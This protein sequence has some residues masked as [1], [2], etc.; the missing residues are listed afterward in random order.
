MATAG[1]MSSGRGWGMCD[2]A[3][4]SEPESRL[5]ES[6][7]EHKS[8]VLN[9]L[10][11]EPEYERVHLGPASAAAFEVE[12]SGRSFHLFCLVSFY[13]LRLLLVVRLQSPSRVGCSRP[14]RAALGWRESLC[15]SPCA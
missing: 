12:L 14:G 6:E 11:P 4:E 15:P 13:L 9:G 8:C 2:V 3:S 7:H 1:C 5:A 10:E